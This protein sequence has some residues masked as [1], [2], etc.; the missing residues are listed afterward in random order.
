MKKVFLRADNGYDMEQASFESGLECKD[1]SL[2]VQSQ[3]DDADINVIVERFGITGQL[4]QS[5]VLPR[6]ED[7][8]EIFDYR[9]AMDA[10]VAAD[11]AFLALPAKI[12]ARFGN[13]PQQ[14]VEFCSDAEN[15]P[16]LRRMGL[17]KPAPEVAASAAAAAAA[18]VP[19]SGAAPT[20]PASAPEGKTS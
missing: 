17:A 6:Y 8:D 4:P 11:R 12:R 20:A 5:A 7:F 3:K 14:F 1:D 2:A 18:A 16:E 15:L 10:V 19:A 13:D 9:T